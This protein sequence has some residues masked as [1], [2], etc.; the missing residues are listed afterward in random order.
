MLI[1]TLRRLSVHGFLALM[2]AALLGLPS[3]SAQTASPCAAALQQVLQN[4]AKARIQLDDAY[5][6]L[7]AQRSIAI[8][9]CSG[10]GSASRQCVQ[11]VDDKFGPMRQNLDAQ[12]T[13]LS[14][15]T[16]RAYNDFAGNCPWSAQEITQMVATLGQAIS[17]ITQSVAQ[18]IS[19]AKGNGS[20]AGKAA[21]T[22]PPAQP[23]QKRSPAPTAAPPPPPK[24]P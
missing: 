5:T 23:P 2:L 21:Q 15:E 3:A 10:S 1:V 19:A 4:L 9:K 22:S 8:E 18:V 16:T 13:L 12:G 11:Q 24:S 17:Q 14:A 7:Q 20:P 6:D